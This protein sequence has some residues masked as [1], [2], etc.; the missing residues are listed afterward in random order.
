MEV[1]ERGE[2]G[3]ADAVARGTLV[4]GLG[5]PILGDDG[6]GWRVIDA[7]EQRLGDEGVSL[8]RACV[9]GVALMERMQGFDRAV[10]VDAILG[11]E[12]S[13]GSLWCRPLAEVV[14][15]TGSHLDSSHDAPLPVALEA[16]RSMGVDLP[17][18]VHVVGIAIERGDVF[19]EE[20]SSAVAASVTAAA[21]LVIDALEAD[22]VSGGPAE[23]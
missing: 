22:A 9:G 18:D 5:N 2:P 11:S 7:L 14:T 21:D 20:L 16:G 6:V 4:I 10:V 23:A 8:Q 15:R 3:T 19:S 1:R 13:P 17:R 12:A